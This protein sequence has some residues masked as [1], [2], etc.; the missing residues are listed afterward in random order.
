MLSIAPSISACLRNSKKRDGHFGQINKPVYRLKLSSREAR[1]IHTVSYRFNPKAGE[2]AIEKINK[3]VALN[4]IKHAQTG[5]VSSVVFVLKNDKTLR[6]CVG[7]RKTIYKPSG[8]C[9]PYHGWL[10]V[11]ILLKIRKFVHT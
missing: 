10:I 11:L 3:M 9:N 8:I 5:W 4:K 1:K 6:L 7:C 2:A